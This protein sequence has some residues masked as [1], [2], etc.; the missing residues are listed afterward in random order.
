MLWPYEWPYDCCGFRALLMFLK[1]I[2]VCRTVFSSWCM[3]FYPRRLISAARRGDAKECQSILF[4]AL[5]N[6]LGDS[7]GE[8]KNICHARDEEGRT[9]L[10][11]SSTQAV[12]KVLIGAKS[13]P[14]LRDTRKRTPLHTVVGVASVDAVRELIA[15]KAD[16]LAKDSHNR[17]PI[18]FM[19]WRPCDLDSTGLQELLTI[20][21]GPEA[22]YTLDR[23]HQRHTLSQPFHCPLPVVDDI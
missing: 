1:F 23:A 3:P 6:N 10:F 8:A 4:D 18:D 12:V 9:A 20:E 19:V 16:V 13:D 14:N 7:P 5:Q 21:G 11:H 17:Q 15:C 2:L 22:L